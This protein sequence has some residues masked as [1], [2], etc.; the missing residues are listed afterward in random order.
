MDALGVEGENYK[1]VLV[2]DRYL[3]PFFFAPLFHCQLL[4]LTLRLTSPPSFDIQQ[5]HFLKY[6]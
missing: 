5:A 4:C 1:L 6:Q 3:E 2:G